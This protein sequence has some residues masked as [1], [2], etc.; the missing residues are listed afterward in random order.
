MFRAFSG[1]LSL[2]LALVVLRLAFPEASAVLTEI[3][4]KSL[5][6][7]NTLL[8]LAVGAALR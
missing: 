6:L 1:A 8:D 2:I 5:K 7:I 4:V 3:I